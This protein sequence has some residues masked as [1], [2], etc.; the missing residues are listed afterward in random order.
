ECMEGT[1]EDI[2][3]EILDWADDFTAP[4]ILWL[5]GY[6]GVGKSTVAT[7]LIEKLRSIGRLGSAFYFKRE[8]ADAMTPRALW[9][10]TAYDL[11]RRYL[12]IR[13]HLVALIKANEDILDTPNVHTLFHQLIIDPLTKT[14]DIPLEHLPVV[15]IDALDECG[16]LDGQ[17]SD[18][19]PSLMKMLGG[20]SRLPRRFKLVVTSRGESD[21]ETLF[22]T[23]IHHLVEVLA[24]QTAKPNSSKDIM[25]FLGHQFVEIA[26]AYKSLPPGWPGLDV[27]RRLTEMAG[28]LFI[29]VDVII[30]FI[31]QGAPQQRLAYILQRN[32]SGGLEALYSSILKVSFPT[33]SDEELRSFRA[34]LGAVILLKNPL[35]ISSLLPLLSIQ[36]STMEYICNQLQSVINCQGILRVHHQSF[37]DFIMDPTACPAGF[38]IDREVE[39]RYLARACLSTMNSGL[40]FN[41]CGLKSSYIRNSDVQDLSSLVTSHISSH[42]SYSSHFWASHLAEI[43]FDKVVHGYLWE[44]MHE[45]F[46]FWLEALSLMKG[47]NLAS[48]MIKIS[49]TWL[50]VR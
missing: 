49:V 41:I 15:I 42:L 13:N 30:K 44:F 18:H 47:V 50:R 8:M 14:D 35:P 12:P 40:R 7:T 28:G 6:P 24:G 22:S 17:R 23:T 10:R 11:S 32:V 37:V 25:V 43:P 48:S 19:R 26:V 27:V 29:W 4:N 5:K 33:P 1:R 3:S 36:S 31:K 45:R 20:W 2:L 16:G 21:I 46:L 34:I 39:H 9:R 38:W